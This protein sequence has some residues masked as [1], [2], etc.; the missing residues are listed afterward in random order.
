[1]VAAYMRKL[2]KP[3][4]LGLLL[5]SASSLVTWL[6]TTSHGLEILKRITDTR[7]K[8]KIAR[9]TDGFGGKTH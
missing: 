8:A 9:G 7:V 2:W 6:M 1:M 3:I 4:V 5:L